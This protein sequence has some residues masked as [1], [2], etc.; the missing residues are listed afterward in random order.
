MNRIQDFSAFAATVEDIYNETLKN[1]GG[2]L[3]SYIPQLANV[4]P[5]QFAVSICTVDGE[6]LD[7]GDHNALFC[8]QSVSKPVTYAM[9]L[10]LVG[11]D[12]VHQHVGREPS[13]KAFNEITLNHQAKPHNPMINAGAMMCT[14]LIKPQESMAKRF[15]YIRQTWQR[16]SA[17]A[18]IGYDNSVYLSEKETGDRNYALAHFM[19]EVGAFPQ[20]TKLKEVLDLYFQCC[21]LEM[22]AHD[23]A[24]VAASF[25]DGGICPVTEEEVFSSETVK[26]TL[27]L[28]LSCGMY[29]FSGEFAFT[30]GLPAKS[31]V[32]GAIMVVI[33]NVM[34]IALWSPRI[35]KVG[36]SVRG[37]EFCQRLI[38][39][40]KF[41]HF[42]SL[43]RNDNDKIDPR[44]TS[45]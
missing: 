40:Y 27:S 43:L 26:N 30:V 21:A 15:D 32:S 42:D 34:G 8:L 23:L 5:D 1:E 2:A 17:G 33:P 24:T 22:S 11:A 20:N 45:N 25:A 9:A 18:R 41:H 38:E 36:N 44:S 31:G 7:F 35:D 4:N 19:R 28:M 14:A 6:R 10:E 39:K 12:K 37:L 29:D 3:A 16:L 13:G